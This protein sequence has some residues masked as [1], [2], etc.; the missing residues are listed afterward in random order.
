MP[1]GSDPVTIDPANFTTVIDNQY[2]PMKP[3]SVWTYRETDAE[4]KVA[5]V[6]VTVTSDTK[7]ILG[8]ETVVVHDVL[9]EDGQVREDTF[10]WYAQDLDGN[11]WYFGEDTKEFTDN[12]VDT[13]GS[14]EAGVDG[15]LPGVIVPADPVPGLAYR[16]EYL[17]G[18]AEDRAIVLSVDEWVEVAAGLYQDVL[19]TKEFTPVEPDVLEYKW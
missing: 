5:T 16:Q 14:W 15:A 9:T 19:L 13:A 4:G 7:Q 18:E 12:G 11:I 1:Q 2:W 8:V 17:A 6:V 10:D 3:G